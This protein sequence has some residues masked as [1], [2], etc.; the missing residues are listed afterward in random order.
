VVLAAANTTSGP[1][2]LNGGCAVISANNSLGYPAT[3]AAVNLNGGALVG[4]ATLALD[5]GGANARPVVLGSNGG[6]LAATAGNTLT[7]DGLVSGTGALTIGLSASSANNHTPG[8]VP[9]SGAGTANAS[10]LATGTVRLSGANTYTGGTTIAGGTLLVA[11]NNGSGAGSGAVTVAG[12]GTLAGNGTVSG[13][14]TMQSGG[15]L[16]PGNPLGTLTISNRVTLEAGSTTQVQVQ[17]SPLAASAVNSSGALMEGGTLSVSN[18]GASAFAA[19]D[20]FKL[21][22]AASYSGAF[23]NCI[24]PPL[25]G[26]LVWNTNALNHSGVLFVVTLTPPVLG[27]LRLAGGNWVMNGSGGAAY[28]PFV[29][30]AST[31][32]VQW[33]VVATNQFDASGNFSLINAVNPAAPQTFYRLQL[34]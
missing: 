17:H 20:C 34:R 13:P 12:G 29:L 1:Y 7:V 8:L 33:T 15:T 11:N 32:L 24:L 9:G 10:M 27:S 5:N 21:F 22:S 25:T 3:A 2:Y 26:N 6:S 31:N 16:A 19:G 30:Q 28:W 14:V 4:N 18:S 23:A